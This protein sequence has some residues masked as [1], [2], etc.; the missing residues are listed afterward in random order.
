M[1]YIG[2]WWIVRTQTLSCIIRTIVYTYGV[3]RSIDLIATYLKSWLVSGPVERTFL[4][5]NL[6]SNVRRFACI[7]S[8]SITLLLSM[9]YEKWLP[10]CVSTSKRTKDAKC[11]VQRKNKNWEKILFFL[12]SKTSWAFIRYLYFLIKWYGRF[13]FHLQSIIN[14]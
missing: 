3:L 5:K 7:I 12:I 11:E 1:V 14:N 4:L 2:F 6:I 13:I 10:L 8:T 9:L